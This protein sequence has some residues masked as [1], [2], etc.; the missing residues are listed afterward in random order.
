[1]ENKLTEAEEAIISE[2]K[3]RI[4]KWE[5]YDNGFVN[6]A[7]QVTQSREED[8]VVAKYNEILTEERYVAT[9]SYETSTEGKEEA[10]AWERASERKQAL[11]YAAVRWALA[12]GNKLRNTGEGVYRE[13]MLVELRVINPNHSA[14]IDEDEEKRA[15]VNALGYEI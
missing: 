3:E 6:E 4:K 10:E 15:N 14:L 2:L 13:D 1:M 9:A 7:A 12:T 5:I 11:K 8:K